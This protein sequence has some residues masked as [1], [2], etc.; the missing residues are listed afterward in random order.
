MVVAPRNELP[1]GG[2]NGCGIKRDI[3]GFFGGVAP[4][5]GAVGHVDGDNLLVVGHVDCVLVNRKPGPGGG[6]GGGASGAG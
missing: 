1:I 6:Q 3:G 5:L 4:Q 2:Q